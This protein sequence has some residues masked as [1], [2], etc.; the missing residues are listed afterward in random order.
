MHA[1]AAAFYPRLSPPQS[2]APAVV[3]FV[4]SIEARSAWIK[5]LLLSVIA[6]MAFT[7]PAIAGLSASRRSMPPHRKPRR[8]SSLQNLVASGTAPVPSAFAR[9]KSGTNLMR[10]L[11]VGNYL[12][13]IPALMVGPIL[14][15]TLI[16]K[17]DVMGKL[18]IR[19]WLRSGGMILASLYG[20]CRDCLTVT[21]S[22]FF[23]GGTSP[24]TLRCWEPTTRRFSWAAPPTR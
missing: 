5:V 7:I 23:A 16:V 17:S 12:F 9:G 2:V 6:M 20:A 4:G 21:T 14:L 19:G 15:A 3:T 22:H 18:V 10:K 8:H 24:R 13:L 11:T 1:A